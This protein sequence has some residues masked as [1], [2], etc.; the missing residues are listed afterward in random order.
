MPDSPINNHIDF[1][2]IGVCN[3]NY[4]VDFSNEDIINEFN[5]G[6]T[7]AYRSVEN[8]IQA[9]YLEGVYTHALTAV[10]KSLKMKRTHL[11][12]KVKIIIEHRIIKLKTLGRQMR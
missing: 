8:E 10:K 4:M 12:T 2:C 3:A 9:F 1:I 6:F 5:N 11:K 7:L